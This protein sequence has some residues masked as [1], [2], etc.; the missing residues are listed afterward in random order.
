[1]PERVSGITLIIIQWFPSGFCTV[2]SADS[3]QRHCIPNRASSIALII[4]KVY[5]SFGLVNTL[6]PIKLI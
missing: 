6:Y 4:I 3:E 2:S 5:Y 1:M